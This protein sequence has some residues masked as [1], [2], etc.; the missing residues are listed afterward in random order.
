MATNRLSVYQQVCIELGET[1]LSGLSEQRKSRFLLDEVFDDVVQECLEAGQWNFAERTVQLDYEP[2]VETQFG[3]RYVFFHPEDWVR[4]T[5]VGSGPYID[6]CPLD[7]YQDDQKNWYSDI[8]PIYVRY[9]SNDTDWGMNL[10][11]WPASFTRFVVLALASRICEAVTQNASKGELLL[12]LLKR[13]KR[14]AMAKD[15][16]RDASRRPAPGNLVMSRFGRSGSRYRYD[17]A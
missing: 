13:G 5:G 9:V 4:T 15:A 16:M 2:D 6:D 12:N 3:Y 11:A 8:T 14:D 1:R 17:R 7:R 10:G